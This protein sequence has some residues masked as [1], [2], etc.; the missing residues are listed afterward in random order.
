MHA[1]TPSRLFEHTALAPQAAADDADLLRLER[2]W[3]AIMSA[4]KA[5]G[6]FHPAQVNEL[7]AIEARMLATPATTAAGAAAKLRLFVGIARQNTP[8]TRRPL[9][10]LPFDDLAWENRFV[11]SALRALDRLAGKG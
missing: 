8:A 4:G 11:V 1:S 6:C 7:D 5:G 10:E 3:H 9:A 2:E